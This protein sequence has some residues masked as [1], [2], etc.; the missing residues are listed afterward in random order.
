MGIPISQYCWGLI[1]FLL[2]SL[3]SFEDIVKSDT[4]ESTTRYQVGALEY[5]SIILTARM[6]LL[7]KLLKTSSDILTLRSMPSQSSC[8]EMKAF[9]W[10]GE[11]CCYFL[12]YGNIDN[13]VNRGVTYNISL[14]RC[15]EWCSKT[16]K[17]KLMSLWNVFIF[18]MLIRFWTPPTIMVSYHTTRAFFHH[19]G[20]WLVQLLHNQWHR[21][22]ATWRKRA[23]RCTLI[24]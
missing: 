1:F 6:T 21:E 15:E 2:C 24:E 11:I 16:R 8:Q 22:N 19:R 7:S 4:F 18:L 5:P 17:R 12:R 20:E 13:G 9:L 23:H 10:K 3:F 14:P